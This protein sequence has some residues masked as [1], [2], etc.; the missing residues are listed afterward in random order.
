MGSNIAMGQGQTTDSSHHMTWV[1]ST[2]GT[3][4][5]LEKWERM[6]IYNSQIWDTTINS[7]IDILSL[8]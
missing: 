2:R 3:S 6:K 1:I 8:F 7:S 5:S 4:Q